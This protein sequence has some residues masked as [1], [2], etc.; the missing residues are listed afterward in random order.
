[1]ISNVNEAILNMAT[2]VFEQ[3]AYDGFMSKKKSRRS[4]GTLYS[5]LFQNIF[6]PSLTDNSKSNR[7]DMCCCFAFFALLFQIYSY[8]SKG[9]EL[10]EKI[11]DLILHK[12][13]DSQ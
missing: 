3:H 8:N 1:M 11:S 5:S 4:A 7:T 10:N 6:V 12:N 2:A 9:Q 13:S